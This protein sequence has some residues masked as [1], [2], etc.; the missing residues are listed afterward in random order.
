MSNE[1][2]IKTYQQMQQECAAVFYQEI[3]KFFAR[4][5]LVLVAQD[6]DIIEVALAIQADNSKQIQE[7]I[8]QEQVIRVHD[9]Y[10]S[11]WSENNATLMAITAVPWVL[12]QEM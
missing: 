5:M 2:T 8:S 7:W 1:F 11:K 10:A 9:E 12:V 3:E 6:L 4:G